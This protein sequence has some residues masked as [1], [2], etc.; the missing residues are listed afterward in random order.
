MF[1]TID[2][3]RRRVEFLE[4]SGWVIRADNLPELLE[5]AA[6]PIDRKTASHHMG[7]S[8]FYGSDCPSFDSALAMLTNGWPEGV[9]KVNAMTAKLQLD[10]LQTRREKYEYVS[11]V[12][13]GRGTVINVPAVV[14]GH[15]LG[16]R[17]QRKTSAE[18]T[19]KGKLVKILVH[20][21]VRWGVDVETYMARG[22]VITVLVALLERAG[23]SVAVDV[24]TLASQHGFNDDA[25]CATFYSAK[26]AGD[27]LNLGML[28]F[29]LGHP[30]SHRRINFML[31]D[32]ICQI[33]PSWKGEGGSI[34]LR[35]SGRFTHELAKYDLVIDSDDM[36]NPNWSSPALAKQWVID[37]AKA[38]GVILEG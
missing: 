5:L 10:K 1:Q 9:A 17:V 8:Y 16:Y 19:G 12:A 31:R 11:S 23:L 14:L 36:S 29:A 30:S 18:K 28:A 26:T 33:A 24:G 34:A 37:M 15:P 13:P 20:N 22:T 27:Y 3:V 35:G 38:Q 4:G 6:V 32:Q 21:G 7:Q 2:D 25:Y